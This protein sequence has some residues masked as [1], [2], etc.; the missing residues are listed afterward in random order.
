ML[1]WFSLYLSERIQWVRLNNFRLRFLIYLFHI[2]QFF[3]KY[4][5]IF[6]CYAN[7]TQLYMFIVPTAAIPHSRLTNCLT[8]IRTCFS[9]NFLKLNAG[10]WNSDTK[11]TFAKSNSFSLL[12]YS[13]VSPFTQV[14]S[15]GIILDNNLSIHVHINNITTFAYFHLCHI[16]RLWP[17]WYSHLALGEMWNGKVA[18]IRWI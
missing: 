16:N 15:L 14:S 6:H 17:W 8:E 5:I 9:I 1:D 7:D 11:S 2:G 18:G 12:I 10:N 13:V 3:R 4:N